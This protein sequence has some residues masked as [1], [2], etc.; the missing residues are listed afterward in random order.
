VAADRRAGDRRG[1]V[2]LILADS[3]RREV[4][5]DRQERAGEARWIGDELSPRR[6][7][8]RRR[9]GRRR[10]RPA[11]RYLGAPPPDEPIDDEIAEENPAW[12]QRPNGSGPLAPARY[13]CRPGDAACPGGPDVDQRGGGAGRRTASARLSLG[14]PSP[15]RTCCALDPGSRST[16]RRELGVG[17]QAG[18]R[19]DRSD[20][21]GQL[22]AEEHLAD[23]LAGTVHGHPAAVLLAGLGGVSWSATMTRSFEVGENRSVAA[24]GRRRLASI[25]RRGIGLAVDAHR[26]A[27]RR[28]PGLDLLGLIGGGVVA[29]DDQPPPKIATA[30]A[31]AIAPPSAQR[32]IAGR[33][34]SISMGRAGSAAAA[35]ATPDARRQRRLPRPADG[36]DV[37]ER[38]LLELGRR[39]GGRPAG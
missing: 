32:L 8:R 34:R 24:W 35:R 36:R 5:V 31:A 4:D 2:W 22:P 14:Q 27:R 13:F 6:P 19:I 37:V 33:R 29:A 17:R 3:A 16:R 28:R 12:P 10:P 20:P 9:H 18:H 25:T 30:R 38:A 11:C 1:V 39:D 26:P 21:V 7:L 15:T 23:R